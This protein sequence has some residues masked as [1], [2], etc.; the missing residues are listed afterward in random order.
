VIVDYVTI[1][2]KKTFRQYKEATSVIS[3]SWYGDSKG[4]QPLKI[5]PTYPKVLL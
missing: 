1:I 4:I 2:Y 3:H 5:T